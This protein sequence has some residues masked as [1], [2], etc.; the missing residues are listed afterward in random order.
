MRALHKKVLVFGAVF[1][2]FGSR[3]SGEE[4]ETIDN[5]EV[6]RY[7]TDDSTFDFKKKIDGKSTVVIRAPK[8]TVKFSTGPAGFDDGSKID[9][10]SKVL[11]EAERVVFNAKI[12]GD[13]VVLII[14]PKGG[15]VEVN[16]K[17]DGK[18]QLYWCKAD[19]KDP[20]PTIKA[21]LDNPRGGAKYNQVTR[22]Q[23]DKLIKEHDLK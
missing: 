11:I 12:D 4:F 19:D 6:K 14:I 16:D 15:S 20:Q 18:S 5:A 9:G 3:V 17:I 10:K 2:A 1:A 21:K 7:A 8:G 23:M 13:S 22:E